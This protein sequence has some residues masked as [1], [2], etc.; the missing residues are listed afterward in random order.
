[1]P[2]IIKPLNRIRITT[3]QRSNAS[4]I[5]ETFSTYNLWSL[6]SLPMLGDIIPPSCIYGRFL[7]KTRQIKC[8]IQRKSWENQVI[9]WRTWHSCG[10]IHWANSLFIT[11]MTWDS[12]PCTMRRI[13]LLPVAKNIFG[14]IQST[15]DLQQCLT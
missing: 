7:N 13:K 5:C 3:T 6:L 15:F 2:W 8:Q 14:I 1:M 4:M 11:R 9:E 12:S 10:Y